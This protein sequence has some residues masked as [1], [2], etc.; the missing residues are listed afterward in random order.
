VITGNKIK[1][2]FLLIL[3]IAATGGYSQ[4]LATA[5][6]LWDD[7]RIVASKEAID[8]YLEEAG[9]EDAEGWL[10][11]AMIYSA[12][13]TDT[14]LKYL[15]ADGRMDAF[16][17]VK[18]AAGLNPKWVTGQLSAGKFELLKVID[19]GCTS[20]GVAFFNAAAER[21][22]VPDYA[23]ALDFFKKAIAVRDFALSQGWKP[24]F[25]SNDTV[26]LYNITQSAINAQR[27]DDAVLYGRKLADKGI[28]SVGNYSKTDF[29]NIYQWLVN[30]YNSKKDVL[31]LQLYAA[32][33]AKI[34]PGSLY[35]T[36]ISI[37]NYREMGNYGQMLMAYEAGI[38]RFP[39]NNALLYSYCSD[40]FTYI[41]TV[42]KSKKLKLN[43]SGKLETNL[44]ALAKAEP[45]S[46]RAYLLLGK[47]YFNMAVDM[48]KA[49]AG[50]NKVIPVLKKSVSQLK[51]F[52]TKSK[53]TSGTSYK[54]GLTLLMNVLNA[55]GE[56][57][58]AER[59]NQ[60]LQGI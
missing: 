5:K 34:Y 56:K 21:R 57:A 52:E 35:F 4:D 6:K 54:E 43:Q 53:S 2:F 23:A 30:Y 13:S 38:K 26:L 31:N 39:Q 42:L 41:Y 16:S 7:K 24:A 45:D 29:E 46:A 25:Q 60:L 47:H 44:A 1:C 20:D 12:I 28:Y 18:K 50:S 3:L 11:K 33:G 27:E 32:K 40:L 19:T 17:A 36:T 58:E 48:Q 9:A 15:V 8:V 49:G 22:S 14:Q 55:V 51:L 10:L 37:N 59:Y